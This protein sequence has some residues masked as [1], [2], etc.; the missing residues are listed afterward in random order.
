MKY[1]SI[2]LFVLAH[3]ATD[4]NQGA[5]PILLPYFIAAHHVSYTAVAMIVFVTNLISTVMQP[6]FWIY[7]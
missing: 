3:A 2:G 5:I 4:L 1:K 6:V 7:C